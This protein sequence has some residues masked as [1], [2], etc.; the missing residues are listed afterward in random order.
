MTRLRAQNIKAGY[1]PCDVIADLSVA[2]E[3][4]QL[5]ALIG[6]NGSGKSTL[7]K[8]LAGL[9][10]IRSGG[11]YL[12]DMNMVDIPVRL[13]AKRMAYL[14]Q[15]RLAQAVM[16]VREILELGRAPYR[17]RLG[18]ISDAGEAAINRAV[19][20]A[21][22]RDFLP[23][24]FGQLSGGEQARVLMGRAL[25]V[26][27][28]ILLAD[29][30]IAALDPYYQI[31]MMDILKAE[32]ARG[33]TVITALHDLSLAHQYADIVWVMDEGELKHMG[34]ASRVLTPEV[35]KSVFRLTAQNFEKLFFWN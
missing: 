8:A 7:I 35:L 5:I 4:G 12:D 22:L 16:T 10:P 6:P 15:E 23:R 30:P 29:E 17:G 18:Q 28:D 27:A 31:A 14:A 24:K 33:K 25:A 26:D 2:A 21:Q 13:R 20:A 34:D 11:I 9:L 3:P 19:E 32:A 1:G